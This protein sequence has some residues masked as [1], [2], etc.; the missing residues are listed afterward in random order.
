ML[1]SLCPFPTRFHYVKQTRQNISSGKMT[2]T[3]LACDALKESISLFLDCQLLCRVF[4]HIKMTVLF[5]VKG[6][7]KQWTLYRPPKENKKLINHHLNHIT[8][9]TVY[10]IYLLY[11]NNEHNLHQYNFCQLDKNCPFVPL[12]W[13]LQPCVIMGS[14]AD[15]LDV[16]AIG[17]QAE[18]GWLCIL[19][20]LA[21]FLCLCLY[22]ISSITRMCS[23]TVTVVAF[24][25]VHP[26]AT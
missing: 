22:G 1:C 13:T 23:L 18:L 14:E 8:M 16:G 9:L 20:W 19:G 11:H 17:A 25:F 7:L 2:G 4:M 26:W 6:M 10:H 5:P 15:T 3:G 21:G 24:I 12:G